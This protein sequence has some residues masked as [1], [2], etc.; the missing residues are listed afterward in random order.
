MKPM[1]TLVGAVTSGFSSAGGCSAAGGSSAAGASVAWGAQADSSI[2][3]IASGMKNFHIFVDNIFYLLH[4]LMDICRSY[5][6]QN[7]WF[8]DQRDGYSQFCLIFYKVPI[9]RLSLLSLRP[10]GT[11]IFSAF[12]DS[13]GN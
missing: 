1:L 12:F 13:S 11:W 9:S 10:L 7:C 2:S 5:I 3:T 8:N 6:T 4:S